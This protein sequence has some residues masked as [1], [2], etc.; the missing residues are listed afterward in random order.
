M[1]EPIEPE[2]GQTAQ[3]RR[4][5]DV[6][7][8]WL[9]VSSHLKLEV[10]RR[11]SELAQQATFVAHADTGVTKH[12]TRD[13]AGFVNYHR[14][15]ACNHYIAMGNGAQ[16][17]VLQI[18]ALDC[19]KRFLAEVENQRE[20]NLKVLKTDKGREYLSEQFKRICEDKGIIRHLT[21]PYSPQQ[22]GAGERRNRTL[23]EMAR[24]MMV[25][26]NLLISFWGDTI[27]TTAYILNRVPSKSILSIPYE[28]WHGRKPNLEGLRPWGSAGFVHSTSHQYGKLGPRASKLIFIRYCEHSKGYV[29]YGEHPNKKND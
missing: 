27:L 25:Q 1:A 4:E 14:V 24:S 20:M 6:Y 23:L 21:I 19:F 5:L 29:M 15:P 9:E 7:N 26:A 10:D 11:E 18:E 17:E 2:N 22:N 8:K 16:E 12:V 3:Y 13:R 28:L